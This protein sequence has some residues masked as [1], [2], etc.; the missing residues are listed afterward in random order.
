MAKKKAAV[1]EAEKNMIAVRSE[2]AHNSL[3]QGESTAQRKRINAIS[4]QRNPKDDDTFGNRA[5][6]F[7]IFGEATK[8]GNI[9]QPIQYTVNVRTGAGPFRILPTLK[10]FLFYAF[11]RN[12][13]GNVIAETDQGTGGIVVEV[14]EDVTSDIVIIFD[15]TLTADGI[16]EDLEL[17]VAY[18]TPK[19]VPVRP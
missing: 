1:P 13:D 12:E 4:R 8:V 10:S 3:G 9:G 6:I 15:S 16:S 17:V 7:V 5:P 14:P 11:L 18:L 2:G 19:T